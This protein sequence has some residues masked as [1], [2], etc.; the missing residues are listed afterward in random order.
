MMFA[1]GA[2]P[3]AVADTPDSGLPFAQTLFA[4]T[5]TTI[6][7]RRL[8]DS[9]DHHDQGKACRPHSVGRLHVLPRSRSPFRMKLLLSLSQLYVSVS[10]SPQ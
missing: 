6:Q 7:A 9:A 2:L 8:R 3:E 5:Y 4:P 1:A 10:R